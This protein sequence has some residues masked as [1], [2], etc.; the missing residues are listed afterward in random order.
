MNYKKPRANQIRPIISY[1]PDDD[2]E[3]YQQQLQLMSL[4]R[5]TTLFKQIYLSLG[6]NVTFSILQTRPI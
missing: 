4:Q 1:S 5:E 3:L 6:M 2:G